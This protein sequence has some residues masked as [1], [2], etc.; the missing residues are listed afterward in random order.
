MITPQRIACSIVSL[1]LA[2]SCTLIDP[3]PVDRMR[4]VRI[5]AL[6]DPKLMEEDPRWMQT[7]KGLIEA[8][9]DYF[10]REFGIR[11][12]VKKIAPWPLAEQTTSTL[13]LITR[14]KEKVPLKDRAGS[15]D[16]IIGFTGETVSLYVSGRARV[17]RI[18]NCSLGLGNYM[19]S[20]VTSS[21][22]YQGSDSE[23][24]WDVLALI[25]EMG[26]IFGAKHTNDSTSIMYRDFAYKTEFDQRSRDV[27]LR[28]RLCPFGKG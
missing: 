1:L 25:H 24:E 8:T 12:V 9:S 10:E 26:H 13:V 4:I 27:I 3:P 11:F 14:L 28:N 2:T 6:G 7:V 5:Q 17:D 19:V 15:Y 16:L 22:Q 23:I 18:G 20:S 21:F